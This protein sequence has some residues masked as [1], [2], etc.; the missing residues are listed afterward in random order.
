MKLAARGHPITIAFLLKAVN[1]M[2]VSVAFSES[3]IDS[4]SRIGVQRALMLKRQSITHE[5]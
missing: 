4:P 3:M 1:A 2:H 5:N